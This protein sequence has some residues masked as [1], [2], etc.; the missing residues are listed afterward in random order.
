[1]VAGKIFKEHKDEIRGYCYANNLSFDRLCKSPCC[2]DNEVLIIQRSGLDPER[3]KLGLKD[4]I[5]T[6]TTL[7]IY[8]E[9]G[10]LRFVQTE[11]TRKC[12]GVTEEAKPAAIP[13]AAVA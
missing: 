9:N 8:L 2:F 1:M 10:K 7:E 13:K 4:N 11:H 6:P 5:P 12:L 3:A